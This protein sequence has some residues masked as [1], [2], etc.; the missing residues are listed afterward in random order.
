MR[1]TRVIPVLL[2]KGRGFYKTRKF[3]EPKYLGDPINILRIFNDKEVDEICVLDIGATSS[4]RGPQMDYLGEFTSECFMPL[5]Y[6]GGITDMDQIR[7]LFK[8][9]AEKCILNTAFH[10]NPALVES[11]AAE[12]GSQSIVISIDVKKKLFGGDEVFTQNGKL[13]T[14]LSA[15]DCARK[16]ESLG[17]GE[18]L[19]N[20]IDR[21]GTMKGYDLGLVEEVCTAVSVPVIL[22]GGAGSVE[23]FK[24]AVKAG[25]SAVAA[26]SFFVF[27]G[28]HRAVL[29]NVPDEEVL[30][31]ELP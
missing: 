15:V 20:S 31:A 3:K 30:E 29:V 14:G 24:G 16:A 19:L 13:K 23:D 21:D 9:G 8:I 25:A 26:G 4:G 5:A 28:P 2:L 7:Q 17:A 27:Q 1:R 18:I 22:C 11:A 10:E 6:G 12:F